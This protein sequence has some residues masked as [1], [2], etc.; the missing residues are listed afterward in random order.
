MVHKVEQLRLDQKEIRDPL[1][2]DGLKRVDGLIPIPEHDGASAQ[3]RYVDEYLRQM[4]QGTI[5]KLASVFG[6]RSSH[7]RSVGGKVS[8]ASFWHAGASPRR[9]NHGEILPPRAAVNGVGRL[10]QRHFIKAQATCRRYANAD[11]G[12]REPGRCEGV[13]LGEDDE[14]RGIDGPDKFYSVLGYL[15][16][17]EKHRASA[18]EICSIPD[19]KGVGMVRRQERNNVTAVD[20]ELSEGMGIAMD[21]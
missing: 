16:A 18:D 2:R 20:T 19:G 5:D 14:Q 1:G 4:G 9:R 6:A 7:R 11:G 10:A 3:E 8:P 15:G 17:G 13:C 12:D 21:G